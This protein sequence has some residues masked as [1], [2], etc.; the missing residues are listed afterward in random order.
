MGLVVEELCIER[1]GL[2]LLQKLF[3]GEVEVIAHR[4]AR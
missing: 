4:F 1:G 3:I 2:E